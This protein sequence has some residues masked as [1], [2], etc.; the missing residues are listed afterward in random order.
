MAT[1]PNWIS[2]EKAMIEREKSNI[3]GYHKRIF[4]MSEREFRTEYKTN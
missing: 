2:A 4:S 1:N 3:P